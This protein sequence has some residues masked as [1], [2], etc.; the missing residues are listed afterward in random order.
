MLLCASLCGQPCCPESSNVEHFI[1]ASGSF[2]DWICWFQMTAEANRHAAIQRQV[3]AFNTE[4]LPAGHQTAAMLHL[5]AT[6]ARAA[7]PRLPRGPSAATSQI[8]EQALECA[9]SAET[10]AHLLR[11]NR[12]PQADTTSFLDAAR[13]QSVAL[14]V[15]HSQDP[16]CD[17]CCLLSEMLLGPLLIVWEH[18]RQLLLTHLVIVLHATTSQPSGVCIFYILLTSVHLARQYSLLHCLFQ[19]QNDQLTCAIDA[20][21][22]GFS[23]VRLDSL[24][25]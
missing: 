3:V 7:S 5:Y 23:N 16:Y 2:Y 22:S 8:L 25:Q 13:A 1:W 6:R 12:I 4:D 20:T 10:F 18:L 19:T 11:A 14:Q 15:S 24:I 9:P 21:I 17:C